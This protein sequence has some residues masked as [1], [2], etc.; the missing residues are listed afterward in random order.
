MDGF[1]AYKY[2]LSLKLHF[3]KETYDV[4]KTRGAVKYSRDQ[5]NR[6]ND[7]LLFEKVAKKYPKDDELIKFYVSNFAYGHDTPVYEM[8]ESETYY[9]NWIKRKES[10]T[11]TVSDDLAV[12]LADAQKNK[13]MK[14]SILYFTFNQQPSI[15]N[16]YIAKRISLE[17]M[18]ILNDYFDLV[19]EWVQSGFMM[20]F[21]EAEVRRIYKVKKFIKYDTNKITPLIAEFRDELND[22]NAIDA[23][24]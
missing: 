19:N 11:K 4:F 18:S 22:L 15:I 9:R 5:Y 3:S 14:E 10:L 16:L 12:I 23:S 1:A 20:T 24:I 21:W 13:L 17:T 2:Y 8:D 6:R 7:K